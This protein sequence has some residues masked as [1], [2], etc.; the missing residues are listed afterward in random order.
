MSVDTIGDFLAIIRN[1]LS[2]FKNSIIAPFSKEKLGIAKVLKEEGYIRDFQ[3]IENEKNKPVLKIFLKYV[4]GEP[5]IHEIVRVSTPGRR[6]YE[7]LRNIKPV[8]G[9]LGISIL[10]T[11]VGIVTDKRAKVLSVGGEVIC[12]VW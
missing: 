11:N 5:V 8:I 1:G 12:R 6:R 3:R 4:S 9:G 7:N 2:T 10:T